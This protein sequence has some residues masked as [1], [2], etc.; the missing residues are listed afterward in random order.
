M[1]ISFDFGVKISTTPKKI[2]KKR[3]D[4]EIEHLIT[5]LKNKNTIYSTNSGC[6][7]LNEFL[8]KGNAEDERD[9]T[10]LPPSELDTLMCQFF[11]NAKKK[12]KKKV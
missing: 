1:E 7:R 2:N 10:E 11:M 9:F 8:R 5:S 6:N 4:E 3:V 12:E